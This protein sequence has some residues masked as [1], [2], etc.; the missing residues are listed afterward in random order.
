MPSNANGN[1]LILNDVNNFNNIR[2]IFKKNEVKINIQIVHP[3]LS[4]ALFHIS[5]Y[6][7]FLSGPVKLYV[8]S[9]IF[10]Y[11]VFDVKIFLVRYIVIA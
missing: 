2:Q 3:S 11:F 5:L 6:N 1:V 10:D 9:I 4:F 7:C 8:I